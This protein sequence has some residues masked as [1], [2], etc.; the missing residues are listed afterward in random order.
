[1][2]F[3]ERF[4]FRVVVW[5]GCLILERKS[6]VEEN[7]F[8]M[9]RWIFKDLLSKKKSRKWSM[10]KDIEVIEKVKWGGKLLVC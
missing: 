2:G 5:K 7:N 6:F 3:E 10:C 8:D 4:V 1:M 9:I